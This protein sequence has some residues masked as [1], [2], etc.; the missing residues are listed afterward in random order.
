[1][2]IIFLAIITI[3]VL[4]FGVFALLEGKNANT[5]SSF[6]Q[7]GDEIGR[8]SFFATL[9]SSTAGLA[10]TLLLIAVYGYFYGLGVFVWVVVF[11]WLTQWASSR[12]IKVVDN[13]RPGFWENRGT[14]HEFFG[15]EFGSQSVRITAA[16]LTVLCYTLLL[17]AEVFLSYRLVFAAT[18]SP[19]ETIVSFPIESGPLSVHVVILA[20]VFIYAAVSGFR[21]VIKTDVFQSIMIGVM[22]IFVMSF[23]GPKIPALIASH[24]SVFGSTLIDSIINPV[25]R[26]PASFLIFF[27]LM[28]LLFWA[29]WWPVAM[30]QWHRVA[31]TKNAKIA[32]GAVLGTS[33]IGV[34]VFV[35][36]LAA[37]VVLI[38]A[39]TRT[40]IAPGGEIPDPLPVF[41]QSL[42]PGGA[43]SVESNW[44]AILMAGIM[45]VGLMAAVV[46]T[47]DTYLMVIVQSVIVDIILAMKGVKSLADADSRDD[48]K[49][50]YLP[51]SKF[52]VLLW[53]VV[54]IAMSYLVSKI[55][56]DAFNIVY[57]GFAFQMAFVSLLLIALFGRPNGRGKQAVFALL[58]GGIWCAVSFPILISQINTAVL[59]GDLEKTYVLLDLIFTN[60][61]AVAIL[62]GFAYFLGNILWGQSQSSPQS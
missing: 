27:V 32:T 17:V 60:T 37:A 19:S 12:T 42:M 40:Y 51:L 22:I 5:F 16:I 9:T 30:D 54:V 11:W 47:L 49:K 59:A 23:L 53:G 56:F 52:F 62:S 33:G 3:P 39:A 15:L 18:T 10:S 20:M 21:A 58:V 46:S 57:A 13:K 31:A 61:V 50:T 41:V 2:S 48:I 45:L 55:T 43:L 44:I 34:R 6:F 28:N 29:A 38:G 25:A 1:M 26:N 4:L 24:E 7:F 14:L 36:L 35:L 8:L